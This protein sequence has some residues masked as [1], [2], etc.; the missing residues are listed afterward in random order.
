MSFSLYDF[1]VS[2]HQ[3]RTDYLSLIELILKNT[4]YSEHRHR[5]QDL[6]KCFR[7]IEA[8]EEEA[9]QQDKAIVM[10]IRQEFPDLF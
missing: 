5:Q 10:Q 4:D 1:V 7:R 8:E 9:S 2:P 6:A 3:I